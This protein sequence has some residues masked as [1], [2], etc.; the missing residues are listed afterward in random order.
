MERRNKL[1]VISHTSHYETTEGIKGFGP[2]VEEINYLSKFWREV[3]HIGMIQKEEAPHHARLYTSENTVFVAI[4]AF[5]G[6]RIGAKILSIFKIPRI[7]RIVRMSVKDAT[8]VQLRVPTGIANFLLPWFSL[9]GTNYQ[10][11]VKYAGNWAQKHPPIG[12]RFQRWWLKRNLCNCKVTINGRW[13]DQEKHCLSFENPCLHTK[14]LEQGNA[15]FHQKGYAAPYNFCFV[16]RI[17]PE[18]GIFRLLDALV[19][20]DRSGLVNRIDIVGTGR[21]ENELLEYLRHTELPCEYHGMLSRERV[22]DIYQNSHFIMLPSTASEGFPKVLAE[23]MN[24]GCI[25]VVS[26]ISSISHYIKQDMGLLWDPAVS[27]FEQFMDKIDFSPLDLKQMAA[28]AH[29]VSE[30]FTFENYHHKL[31]HLVFANS[32]LPK[33]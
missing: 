17:E 24:F 9:R 28:K 12:Y 1:V 7:L 6:R 20:L 32:G 15:S 31:E 8:E 21:S 13:S 29:K 19:N 23:A 2:T 4:P 3:V 5:G 18:K 14:D 25:P 33:L 11:W 16:G 26:T 30:E 27:D 22:F 10:F